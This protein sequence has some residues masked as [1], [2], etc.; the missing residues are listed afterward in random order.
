[1][2]K[3][4]YLALVLMAADVG[5]AQCL[6][7]LSNANKTVSCDATNWAF[8]PPGYTNCE[9]CAGATTSVTV[10]S[11]TP[12]SG[13]P[14]S[15]QTTRTW[16][17]SNECDSG[18]CS[19]TVTVVNG[20]AP[21]FAGVSNITVSSCACVPV[22][23][24]VTASEGCCGNLPVSYSPTN[25]SCFPAGLNTTVTCSVTDCCGNTYSTNFS[26]H[27]LDQQG[28][29]ANCATKLVA[30]GDTNWA[31]DPPSVYD[32][33]CPG[34]NYTFYPQTPVTNGT[35]C[36][37][38]ITELWWVKDQCGNS[39]Y[40]TE[41]VY[42]TNL[43][44][45][46]NPCPGAL[47]TLVRNSSGVETLT[48]I[49]SGGITP[50]CTVGSGFSALAYAPADLGNGFGL[51]Y[52]ISDTTDNDFCT[53]DFSGDTKVR[54]G[55]FPYDYFTALTFVAP[56]AGN[57][58]NKLYTIRGGD[59]GDPA[60]F[61]I[62]YGAS[63]GVNGI[64]LLDTDPLSLGMGAGSGFYS[65]T[66]AAPDLGWG[67]NL[68][69]AL[70]SNP[71]NGSIELFTFPVNGPVVDRMNLGSFYF[72]GI[73]FAPDDLGW[74]PNLLYG[75]AHDSELHYFLLTFSPTAPL[76]QQLDLGS[77]GSAGQLVYAPAPL[78]FHPPADVVL[79]GVSVARVTYP[80]SVA[81]NQC[82]G[83]DISVTYTPPSG[84]TFG[85]GTSNVMCQ[86][87]DCGGNTNTFYFSVEIFSELTSPSI[88]GNF[89]Y[90]GLFKDVPNLT[91]SGEEIYPSSLPGWTYSAGPGQL[92]L[93]DSPS[94]LPAVQ[95]NGQGTPVSLSQTFATTPGMNYTVSFA[96]ND[97]SDAGPSC[98]ELTVSV[99]GQMRVFSLMNDSG[100]YLW[101]NQGYRLQSMGFTAQSDLTTLTFTDT[102]TAACPSPFLASVCVNQGAASF[103][104]FD[105]AVPGGPFGNFSGFTGVPVISG[106]AAVFV[107]A[108]E[109]GNEGVYYVDAAPLQCLNFSPPAPS[110]IY[111]VEVN[112][113][114]TI[115]P[116][117]IGPFYVTSQPVVSSLRGTVNVGF[118]GIGYGGRDQEGV[119]GYA[120]NPALGI[121]NGFSIADTTTVIPNPSVPGNFTEFAPSPSALTMTPA[122]SASLFAFWGANDDGYE[123]ICGT[124]SISSNPMPP[125]MTIADTTMPIPQGTGNIATFVN[126]NLAGAG[127][128]GS[129]KNFALSGNTL[130]FYAA[131]SPPTAY[132]GQQGIY[133]V[134]V[135][136]SSQPIPFRVADTTM[137]LPNGTGTYKY[138]LGLDIGAEPTSGQTHIVFIAVGEAG[139]EAICDG[140]IGVAGELNPVP[141]VVVDNN[142][143]IPNDSYGDTFNS[144]TTVACGGCPTLSIAFVATG[145]HGQKGIYVIPAPSASWEY[146][147]PLTKVVDL[148]DTLDGTTSMDL[149]MGAGALSGTVLTFEATHSEDGSAGL[150]TVPIIDNLFITSIT[151]PVGMALTSLNFTAPSGYGYY[152]QSTPDLAMPAWVAEPS[153]LIPGNGGVVT[154]TNPSP[155][156]QKFYRVYKSPLTPGN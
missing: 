111:R 39:N 115:P 126:P 138:F 155:T 88:S 84:S 4:L 59:V 60:L 104:T 23:F 78:S 38:T 30:C 56:D 122:I 57:G 47:Y 32:T 65:I 62:D 83:T 143:P 146:P 5:R 93:D 140:I 154:V 48:A 128:A 35:G 66:F 132:G 105:T 91:G 94:G 150:Y 151:A 116:G 121:A 86:V 27:V 89:L 134:T 81:S 19:Q 41:T 33:C 63:L 148:N 53:I 101:G 79:T 124:L 1:M 127:P 141:W 120:C 87:V 9:R 61:P 144:F 14:C 113:S 71:T 109:Y 44:P 20:N 90:D 99:G 119:Y 73:A 76:T 22:Y 18:Q 24:N 156:N 153:G 102:S 12:L 139:Q 82:C 31:F 123:A 103:A 50:L 137:A 51:F 25:G 136:V 114:T 7:I 110:T 107:G 8:D 112:G 11:T 133:G 152:V 58:P 6:V 97:A 36:P 67:P 130:A 13:P 16:L 49:N 100:N 72:D 95:F 37:M 75:M 21:V 54:F 45:T 142:T 117:G 40:C 28:L 2:K 96:Q 70:S 129:S 43:P 69:Y 135:A 85:I 34:T 10:L 145:P 108:D 55:G 80:V 92:L 42:V 15:Q 74:G 26:V 131:G 3:L 77:L 125:L 17:V 149:Q 64:V 118:V 68:F 29:Q 46:T 147:F 106:T 52:T 98:S